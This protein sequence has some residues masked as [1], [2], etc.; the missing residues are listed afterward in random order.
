[1]STLPNKDECNSHL[2]R[3]IV[4]LI[5]AIIRR[6]PLPLIYRSFVPPPNL[7]N[8]SSRLFQSPDQFIIERTPNV[9]LGPKNEMDGRESGLILSEERRKVSGGMDGNHFF[10]LERFVFQF[11]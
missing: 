1:M 8:H 9:I 2:P 10:S 4:P 6:I 11:Y 3:I 5:R 7:V